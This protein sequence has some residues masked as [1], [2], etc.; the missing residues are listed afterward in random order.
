MVKARWASI[1][2]LAVSLGAAAVPAPTNKPVT[3]DDILLM[4][5]NY[6]PSPNVTTIVKTN[7]VDFDPD[8]DY[9]K[10][11]RAAG[12]KDDLLAALREAHGSAAGHTT[13]KRPA[14]DVEVD[15]H[16]SR[17]LELEKLESYPQAEQEY[18]AALVVQPQNSVLRVGLGRA[19]AKQEKWDDAL[20]QYREA[21]R[22][23]SKSAEAHAALGLAIA[24]RGDPET[25]IPELQEALRLNPHDLQARNILGASYWNIHDLPNALKAWHD[26]AEVAP[27]TAAGHY[28]AACV[29]LL[30]KR[31]ADGAIT[32]FRQAISI[33][34]YTWFPHND[35]ANAISAKGDWDG[36]IFEYR[37]ALRLQ[38]DSVVAHANLGYALAS[39]GD[40]AGGTTEVQYAIHINPHTPYPHLVN[41]MILA[42]QKKMPESISEY[43]ETVR[44]DP[45]NSTA[46]MLL[47]GALAGGGDM[48]GAV[49][50]TREAARLE[51]NNQYIHNQLGVLLAHSGDNQGG[52][53][54]YREA[55]RL[56]PKYAMAHANLGALLLERG[57]MSLP[58][59][60]KEIG[61]AYQLDPKNPEI[62]AL[63]KKYTGGMF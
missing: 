20:A 1:I 15:Q 58:E 42:V 56:D 63:Y 7:G 44:L 61:T 49:G 53:A 35:Y 11:V 34:P 29:L 36:A 54:E 38:P 17:A 40:L 55:I 32:E 57:G 16:F 33:D 50:E 31:D 3:R 8:T 30:E 45:G 26:N 62:M 27:D 51:P 37:Q 10:K 23:D 25:A 43:R 13:V 46:H 6:V 60:L 59:A 22:I 24:L 39:K 4:L 19:L 28:A 21:I 52:E 41:G 14:S 12:G 9:L 47:G 5:N 18:R 48:N 2:L